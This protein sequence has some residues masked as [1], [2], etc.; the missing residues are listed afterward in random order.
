MNRVYPVL[1]VPPQYL[2][3]GEL[4][5]CNLRVF[6]VGRTT[7]AAQPFIFC[8]ILQCDGVV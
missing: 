4:D 7:D 1:Q 6:W 8:L 2:L 5:P 3:D